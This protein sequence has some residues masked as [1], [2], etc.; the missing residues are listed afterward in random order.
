ME[1]VIKINMKTLE[2][3]F[4]N[5][6]RLV[7]NEVDKLYFKKL[8][9]YIAKRRKEIEV[10]PVSDNVFRAFELTNPDDVTVIWIGLDPYNNFSAW[11][12][13]PVADGL[14]FSTNSQDRTPPSLSKIH[15]AIEEDC[16]NDLNLEL[17][18]NLEYLAKQGVL[19][20]NSYLTV[21]K[22]NSLSHSK[23]GWEEFNVSILNQLFNDNLPRFVIT[24]G[25]AA[26]KLIE[27]C[28]L[29]SNIEVI[30]LEHPA[31][32]C[33]QNRKLEHKNAFSKANSFIQKHYGIEKRIKW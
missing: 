7:K 29:H 33:R 25:S 12:N 24:F 21:E 26:K 5:W 14:C 19:L 23:I 3:R 6:W 31:Y 18:N 9:N 20:L 2:E 30:N 1:Q 10:Y 32:A 17:D 13:A 22:F 16:Y 15:Q 8:A 27:E 4:G 11:T 28:V